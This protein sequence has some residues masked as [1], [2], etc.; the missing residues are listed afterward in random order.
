MINE[1]MKKEYHV[2]S[3]SNESSYALYDFPA[4]RA[5]NAENVSI[6]HHDIS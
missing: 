3:D 1:K 4:Q 5:G 6:W 2:E